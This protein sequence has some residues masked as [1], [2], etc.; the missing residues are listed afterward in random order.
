MKE[1]SKKL[2]KQEAKST[3]EIIRR[4]VEEAG[5]DG[6]I[7][8]VEK[9]AAEIKAQRLREGF[10]PLAPSYKLKGAPKKPGWHY[11]WASATENRIFELKQ[12]GYEVDETCKPV[13]AGDNSNGLK[14]VRMMIPES[15]YKE[16]FA[17]RMNL[18]KADEDAKRKAAVKGGVE[19][20]DGAYGDI[21]IGQKSVKLGFK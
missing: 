13:S 20:A 12:Q 6:S 18:I 16:D 5:L 8:D 3:S 4:D 7:I 14:L 1:E 17:K 10:D 9:R 21:A 11:F 15:I 2:D 19:Q